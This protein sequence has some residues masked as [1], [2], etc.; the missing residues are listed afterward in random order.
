MMMTYRLSWS[1]LENLSGQKPPLHILELFS[2]TN[3]AHLVQFNTNL[4]VKFCTA[5]DHDLEM[6]SL[7]PDIE[8]KV[9]SVQTALTNIIT[10]SVD[11]YS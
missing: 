5:S 7:C 3:D 1:K 11:K 9:V 4:C 8:N 10:D 6:T 2:A